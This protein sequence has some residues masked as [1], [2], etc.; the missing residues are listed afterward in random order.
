ML[1][2][3][4]TG[5]E[6]LKF[7]YEAREQLKE[8]QTTCRRLCTRVEI[9]STFLSE[10]KNEH[11]LSSKKKSFAGFER[12]IGV[13]VTLLREV[14]EYVVHH[15]GQSTDS[16][17]KQAQRMVLNV[18]F[19]KSK[20]KELMDFNQRINDCVHNLMPG[21]VVNIENQRRDDFEDFNTHMEAMMQDLNES[22]E[23]SYKK[24]VSSLQQALSDIK[25]DCH[26]ENQEFVNS[27]TSL[28]K[29]V[30]SNQKISFRDLIG[31]QDALKHQFQIVIEEV[32]KDMEYVLKELLEVK[33]MIVDLRSGLD[34]SK[35][36]ATKVVVVNSIEHKV[37]NYLTSTDNSCQSVPVID[38]NSALRSMVNLWFSDRKTASKRY[39]D[40]STW[41][42]SK[43]TDMRELFKDR[44]DFSYEDIM[45]WDLN[46]VTD[47]TDI[48]KGV[49]SFDKLTLRYAVVKGHT[50]IVKILLSNK[51]FSELNAKDNNVSDYIL[52]V[53]N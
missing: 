44:T 22:L 41:D 40:I 31:L 52:Y 49:K 18:T 4:R 17:L 48:F 51:R 27:L 26:N 50:N 46:N 8:N 21:L 28:E 6:I 20:A 37:G 23:E 19:R 39:G 7:L 43:V 14:K 13:L 42:T 47:I 38:A 25:R 11:I 3:V 1:E 35:M 30:L 16:T 33:G 12:S 24:G 36:D 9:F 34:A 2:L 53:T 29:K 10:L 32:K 15:L 45:K 5:V